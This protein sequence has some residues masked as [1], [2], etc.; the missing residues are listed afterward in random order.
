MTSLHV[1]VALL[2][3]LSSGLCEEKKFLQRAGTNYNS[4]VYKSML[5]VTNGEQ[6][7]SWTWPEM[8]PENFFAV[9]FSIRVEPNQYGLDDTSMNGIRLICAQNEDRSFVYSIESHTGYFGD[10]SQPQY[11]PGGVLS[12]FQLRVEPH[13]GLFGDDTTVNNIKFR[14]ST[15]PTLEGYGTTWGEY[16][17]W[18]ADCVDGGICG[19]ESKMEEYQYGLD[20]STLNDVRFHC[21]AFSQQQRGRKNPNYPQSPGVYL[22]Q[23]LDCAATNQ[24]LSGK[25]GALKVPAVSFGGSQRHESLAPDCTLTAR[26]LLF[27]LWTLAGNVLK[28]ATLAQDSVQFVNARPRFIKLST[29]LRCTERRNGKRRWSL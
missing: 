9:G 2:A 16:G 3:V 26:I 7:G 28:N 22:C 19:V 27:V 13:Q 14:C 23:R 10:W 6:F 21:C 15:N 11:C 1:L 18:S 20:D 5:T 29:R 8:C 12:S 25:D 4:R 17:Y 24:P